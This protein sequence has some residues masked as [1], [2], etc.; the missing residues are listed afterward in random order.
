MLAGL[1]SHP[2]D[3]LRARYQARELQKSN[4]HL[5]FDLFSSQ[6]LMDTHNFYRQDQPGSTIFSGLVARLLHI[7]LSFTVT[8]LWYNFFL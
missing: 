2:L 3:A 1:V 5:N 6:Y 8:M 4:G 7:I